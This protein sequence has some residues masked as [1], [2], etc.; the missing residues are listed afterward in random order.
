MPVN[1]ID[2]FIYYNTI[3]VATQEEKK[4]VVRMQDSHR[5]SCLRVIDIGMKE[6]FR[7]RPSS[8]RHR[9]VSGI[10][11][12]IRK[13]FWTCPNIADLGYHLFHSL[14]TLV[15]LTMAVSLE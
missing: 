9:Y 10:T 8:S 11:F 1:S 4:K 13:R 2:H 3:S 12:V 5:D 6:A 7:L 15:P 14:S